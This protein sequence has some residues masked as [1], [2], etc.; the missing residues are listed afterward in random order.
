M[1]LPFQPF[2]KCKALA[3]ER[4]EI[5]YHKYIFFS[6]NVNMALRYLPKIFCFSSSLSQERIKNAFVT[7]L[8]KPHPKMTQQFSQ[9][10]S[11]PKRNIFLSNQKLCPWSQFG[12]IFF[13]FFFC[14]LTRKVKIP[15]RMSFMILVQCNEKDLL[16]SFCIE[17]GKKNPLWNFAWAK[18]WLF[19]LATGF[20]SNTNWEIRTVW[21]QGIHLNVTYKDTG[22]H[23][24]WWLK[25]KATFR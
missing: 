17:A 15:I 8:K 13:F 12:D 25:R 4:T 1:R 9:T 5:K 18:D 20:I 10:F 19:W 11:H 16:T 2:Q 7:K 3:E 21:G 24:I 14:P 6:T 23:E 22:C